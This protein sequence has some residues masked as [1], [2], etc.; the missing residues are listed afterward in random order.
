MRSP[1]SAKGG[2]RE[3]RGDRRAAPRRLQAGG[4]GRR[5][6]ARR[7]ARRHGGA[8]R[9]DENIL[10]GFGR[11]ID[12]RRTPEEFVPYLA[13]WVDY[14]WLLLDPPDNPYAAVEQPF[15]GGLG[16]LRELVA[17]AATESKWRGTSAGMVRIL[18]RATGVQGYR[19]EEIVTDQSGEQLPFRVRVVAPREAERYLDLV[20]RI[21]EHE[22]PAHVIATVVVEDAGS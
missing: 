16:R 8:A 18:E 1:L 14:A 22:K 17:S 15:S 6:P 3:A 5:K 2:H 4:V 9:R 10:T 11:Y 7:R 21:V 12:P 13:T 20:R 19:V